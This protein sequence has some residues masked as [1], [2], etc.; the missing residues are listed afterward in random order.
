MRL[1]ERQANGS[2]RL[3]DDL[4]DRDV[5]QCPYA[6]LSHR[7]GHT[8]DEVTF[9]DIREGRGREKAGYGKIEFCAEQASK[10]GLRYIWIDTCCINKSSDP[11]ISEAINSMYRWYGRATKCYVYMTDVCVLDQDGHASNLTWE[12][13]FRASEWH[14]RGWTLQELLAPISVEFFSRE[15]RRLGDKVALSRMIHEITGID[16]SALHDYREPSQFSVDER[17]KWAKGRRTTREEDWAYSLLGIFGIS[18][19]LIYGEGKERAVIRLRKE[20]HDASV[21]DIQTSSTCA[22]MI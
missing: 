4:L 10:D 18:M 3:T 11:E 5:S 17:F 16:N 14:T 19:P 15:H 7:W 8:K 6:I 22:P 13:Q 2:V 9:E 1:L 20:I 21:R 12:E